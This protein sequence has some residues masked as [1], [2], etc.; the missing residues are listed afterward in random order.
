MTREVLIGMIAVA[1][2]TGGLYAAYQREAARGLRFQLEFADG[3]SLKP[4]DSVY[5]Q[6][7][8]VGEVHDVDLGADRKVRV[9]VRL[10]DRFKALVLSESQFMIASDK[11]IFGKMAV[12]VSPP[13][14][15]GT[16]V[17][18]GQV[19][20]G[21]EGYAEL[22]MGK[23]ATHAKKALEALRGWITSP[24]DE[25]SEEQHRTP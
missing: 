2:A 12:V 1:L 3:A 7:V 17:H 13:Q 25:H 10:S 14:G 24:D 21:V 22:Y 9:A 15:S 16:P 19:L 5:M 4:G 8:D 18:E 11:F 6:G 23:T 20:K